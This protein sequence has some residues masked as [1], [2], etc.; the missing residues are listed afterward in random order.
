MRGVHAIAPGVYAVTA[1]PPP[2][3]RLARAWHHL[4][5]VLLGPPLPS[6]RER[7]ERLGRL[8]ALAI[9][10]ADAISSSVYGPE[11]ML[12][13]LSQAGVP[14]ISAYALP[15]AVAIVALLGILALSYWQTI[16]AYPTGAGGYIVATDNLGRVPGLVSAAA[17]L[18]DYTS[19]SRCRSPLVSKRLLQHYRCSRRFVYPWRSADSA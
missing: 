16:T 9:L 19:T 12:R 2:H 18:I 10:G 3:G 14:A 6:G 7:R 8:A 5:R 11:E 13:V 17:L 1:D 4:K 15:I